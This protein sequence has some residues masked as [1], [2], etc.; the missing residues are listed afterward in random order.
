M[1]LVGCAILPHGCMTLDPHKDGLPE[2]ARTLHHACVEAAGLVASWS[3]EIIFLVTP[4]GLSLSEHL[5]IYMNGN[6]AG[7]AEWRENWKEFKVDVKISL[8]TSTDLYKH[9]K[10]NNLKVETIRAFAGSCPIVL[11]WG[12]VVPL[13]FLN[14]QLQQSQQQSKS[15]VEF[16]IL[17]PT[18]PSGNSSVDRSSL[19]PSKIPENLEFGKSIRKFIDSIP[20]KVAFVVSGDLAHTHSVSQNFHERYLSNSHVSEEAKPYDSAIEKWLG[21]LNSEVLIKEAASLVPKALSCGFDG[22]VIL[23]GILGLDNETPKKY[24]T[25]VLVNCAP[26]YYGMLVAVISPK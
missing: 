20:Q 14:Q 23:Q 7:D 16:V 10:G 24:S 26:T 25:K 17:S 1:V 2:Q 4:H 18:A 11:R 22:F 9:L 15:N 6:A 13:W 19:S 5:G 3:P 21:T 8:Q 12:E